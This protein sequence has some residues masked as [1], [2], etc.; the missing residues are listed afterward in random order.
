M[1]YLG[2]IRR[3]HFSKL[4]LAQLLSLIA[5]NLL[6][7]ALIIRVFDLTQGTRFAN[8]SVALLV[9]SFGI[10]SVLFAAV[11]GVYVDHWD[12]KKVLVVSNL[13]RAL[14]VLGYLVIQ[15]NLLLV[16]CLTFIISTITQFFTPAEAAAIPRLVRRDELIS[17]NG[18]FVFTFY[19]TFV[20]G[21]SASAPIIKFFGAEAPFLFA[22]AMFATAMILAQLLPQMGEGNQLKVA[23]VDLIRSTGSELARSRRLIFANINLYFPIIQLMLIQVMIGVVMVLAPALSLSLLKL[24]LRDASQYL[25]L[26]AGIGMVVG[27]MIVG[28]LSAR[29]SKLTLISTGLVIAGSALAVLGLS[30]LLH[31]SI[32]GMVIAD[33]NQIGILAAILVLALGIMN[34]IVSVSSQTILQE[35]S[36]DSTRGKIFGALNAMV[37]L[38]ATLPVLLAGI[39]ADLTSVTK[40]VST[41][42]LLVLGF[43]LAQLWLLRHRG[44]HHSTMLGPIDNAED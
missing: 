24:P 16:L 4:W 6:N 15:D 28:R 27:V 20:V 22:S 19:A 23:L 13:L 5:Q 25:I 11:A 8:V 44:Y 43:A 12:R 31:R 26:P 7:F 10:P 3:G 9:L 38:A 33:P 35:N 18:L 14:L 34:A 2:V 29:I 37:N 17:A 36:T 1:S 40:V 32:N 21:Y 41:T 42:G 30:G 39:L